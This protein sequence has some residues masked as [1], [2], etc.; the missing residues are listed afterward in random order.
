[1][2]VHR[3]LGYTTLLYQV[4]SVTPS[5]IRDQNRDPLTGSG[6][7]PDNKSDLSPNRLCGGSCAAFTEV[8]TIEPA[9]RTHFMG[10]YYQTE[11]RLG[12][13]GGVVCRT[14]TG[15][16]A[17][18]AIAFD[19]FFLLTFEFVLALVVLVMRNVWAIARD[20]AHGHLLPALGAVS[21]F[22]LDRLQAGALGRRRGTP[23]GNARSLLPNPHGRL[24]RKSDPGHLVLPARPRT[25]GLLVRETR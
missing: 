14:Y 21:R 22:P 4:Q 11:Y 17:Y 19:L 10:V 25:R 16:R 15:P 12:R 9:R 7:S 8:F 18:L 1:M 23:I 5:L 3:P 20:D 13:R 2:T 6:P 24:V